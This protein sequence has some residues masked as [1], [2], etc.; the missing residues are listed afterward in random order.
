MGNSAINAQYEPVS[1]TAPDEEKP[2]PPASPAPSLLP[3]WT[4]LFGSSP[5]AATSGKKVPLAPEKRVELEARIGVQLNK[6]HV[7]QREL[8]LKAKN[9]RRLAR[10]QRTAGDMDLARATARIMSKCTRMCTLIMSRI[11]NLEVLNMHIL[12]NEITFESVNVMRTITNDLRT[13]LAVQGGVEGMEAVLDEFN[14]VIENIHDEVERIDHTME[15]SD[16]TGG[17]PLSNTALDSL[18]DD[19]PPS[20]SAPPGAALTP[21]RTRATRPTPLLPNKPR[22]AA[23]ASQ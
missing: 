22:A 3:G 20:S 10:E 5:T 2:E 1:A 6:L 19:I 12:L 16:P 17:F 11:E 14:N 21:I 7:Q 13:E 23:T 18:L 4:R 15:M 8:D 9:Y